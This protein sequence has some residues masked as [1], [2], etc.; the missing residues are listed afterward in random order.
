MSRPIIQYIALWNGRCG[1]SVAS[2]AQIRREQGTAN[3][4]SIRPATHDDVIH[5]R[6]MGGHVPV[7][8]IK[9]IR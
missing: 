7:G 2:P 5:V 8:R 1:L 6:A 9:E 3:I 4:K